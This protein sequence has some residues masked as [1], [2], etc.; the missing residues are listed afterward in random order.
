MTILV[1]ISFSLAVVGVV[2]MS[3][4]ELPESVSGM[5]FGL[6]VHKRW[7][8][9]AWLVAVAM[10]VMVP[11]M[12]A[13]DDAAWL[14]WLTVVGLVG[15]AV[16]PICNGDTQRLHDVFGVSA[17]VLSQFCVAC[18]CPWWLLVW[19]LWLPLLAGAMAA[20]NDAKESP[21][22]LGGHGVLAAELTCA[23]T[24]YGSLMYS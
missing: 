22:L 12:T 19:L 14:G 20:L 24:M 2:L 8:W 18:L 21:R 9:S 10:A 13:L 23:V 11:L 6:P 16:T 1:L 3:R 15:A 7:L 4:R 17:G 5:V